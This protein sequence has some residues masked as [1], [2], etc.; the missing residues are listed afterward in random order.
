MISQDAKKDLLWFFLSVLIAL[1]HLVTAYFIVFPWWVGF[2]IGFTFVAL[3][4]LMWRY[5]EG[6]GLGTCL[7]LFISF[8][9]FGHGMVDYPHTGWRAIKHPTMIYC[10][11]FGAAAIIW[12]GRKALPHLDPN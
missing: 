3:S 5:H 6:A 8:L 9:P 4:P 1:I 11:C 7:V 10:Y 2:L 12:L